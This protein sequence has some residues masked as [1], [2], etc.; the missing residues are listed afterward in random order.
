[1]VMSMPRGSRTRVRAGLVVLFVSFGT[2]LATWA[3]HLPTLQ[4]R[5]GIS[6]A[7]LGT[8]VLILGVGAMASMQ[9]SGRLTDRFGV[10]AV[11]LTSTLA[12]AMALI[13]PLAARTLWG[14][15]L[16]AL[17]FGAAVGLTDVAINAMAVDVE[18]S[19]GRPIMASF[20]G[21][22]SIGTVFGSLCAAAAFSLGIGVL[23]GVAIVAAACAA[24][25][26]AAAVLLRQGLAAKD[27]EEQEA[28]ERQPIRRRPGRRVVA[29]GALAFFLFLA[30]GSAMDWSSL[31]AQRH[32]H[33]TP[34]MGTLVFGGFVSAL[35]V[36]RFSI[37][38]IAQRVGAIRVVRWGSA[39]AVVGLLIVILAP[40]LP[41][42]IVGWIVFGFALSG[43]VPQVFTAAGTTSEASAYALSHVVGF[44][45]LAIL[46]GPGVIGWLAQVSSLNASLLVP[47]CAVLAC[48][49]MAGTVAARPVESPERCSAP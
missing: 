13:A 10:G 1:M 16:G 39:A 43:G 9:V 5:T 36:G 15:S 21:T 27:P 11:A 2:L 23:V 35:T 12:M 31:H 46:A 3:V 29:L 24:G 44:G 47:L 48:S 28:R 17:V 4:Q 6:T 40:T 30:E 20:H 38:R 22:Y 14:A 49:L 7:Q 26:A 41:L 34:F 32:L 8:V 19:Y 37:D 18:R 25:V 45:Y 33:A 42:L